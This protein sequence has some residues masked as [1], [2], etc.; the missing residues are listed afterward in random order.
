MLNLLTNGILAANGTH[1]GNTTAAD[2]NPPA[3]D[4]LDYFFSNRQYDPSQP[5]AFLNWMIVDEE[6][7]KVTSSFHMGSVQ[8]QPIGGTMQKQPLTGLNQLTV[9][10]GGWLYMYVSNESNQDVYFDDLVINHKRGPVVET[11]SYYAFGMEIPGLNAKAIG[12]GTSPQNRKKYNGGNELQSKEF[13]DGSGLETYDTHFRQLDPQIGRW[14]QIDPKP[15]RG[16]SPYAAMGNNPI[17]YNDILGDTLPSGKH[18]YDKGGMEEFQWLCDPRSEGYGTEI[19]L[20][21]GE[22]LYL[23][24][25]QV[26]LFAM[27][28]GGRLL[29]TAEQATSKATNTVNEI[30]SVWKMENYSSRGFRVENILGGN[31]PKTFKTF[32]R[33]I[34][35]VASSIKSLD[36]AAKSYNKGNVL[37]STIKGYVNEAANFTKYAMRDESGTIVSLNS[38]DITTRTVEL[39]IQAGKGTL[40]QWEQIADAM[41][42]GQD[43]GVRV[44]INFLK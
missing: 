12:F 42:Y 21:W 10:R 16:E 29:S 13:S 30:G 5:K 35:G 11:N 26:G 24:G 19:N 38:S 44:N 27:P 20:T 39:A 14:W 34:G 3:G 1:G 32:D 6:F 17:K 40:K 23:I 33:F 8:V 43:H 22:R 31:L 28:V 4:V 15:E 18:I 9:R 36:L 25:G 37:L 2:I 41:K 7:N